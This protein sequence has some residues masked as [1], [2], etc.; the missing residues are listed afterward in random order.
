MRA[1]RSV[2]GGRLCTALHNTAYAFP[3]VVACIGLSLQHQY[4]LRAI[5]IEMQRHP[6]PIRHTEI[7]KTPR[8]SYP[9]LRSS[10]CTHQYPE[11]QPLAHSYTV[12]RRNCPHSTIRYCRG[13]NARMG[14]GNND[15]TRA[16]A[17]LCL[18]LLP[19]ALNVEMPIECRKISLC[20]RIPR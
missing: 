19:L 16:T 12:K 2:Y 5:G 13:N 14:P 9:L 17:K 4:N 15:A 7:G 8:H 11:L 6:A 3:P 10:G 20:G 18:N 1:S